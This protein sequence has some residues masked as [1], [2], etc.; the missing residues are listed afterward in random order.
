MVT[1]PWDGVCDGHLAQLLGGHFHPGD[2]QQDDLGRHGLVAVEDHGAQTTMGYLL[3]DRDAA[4]C[5]VELCKAGA[6]TDN[7]ANQI[8]T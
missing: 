7:G 2:V 6:K 4:R 3:G 1:R 5:A 8:L